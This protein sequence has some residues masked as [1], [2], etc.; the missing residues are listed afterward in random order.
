M[1]EA[2]LI[3]IKF[4]TPFITIYQ[5]IGRDKNLTVRNNPIEE[6]W[7]KDYEIITTTGKFFH[8]LQD[9][10]DPEFQ[11]QLEYLLTDDL[12]PLVYDDPVI[13][14]S[15]AR[16]IARQGLIAVNGL[17]IET[18]RDLKD[19]YDQ[20]NK[21]LEAKREIILKDSLQESENAY[22]LYIPPGY[23]VLDKLLR[24]LIMKNVDIFEKNA[25][26][27]VTCFSVGFFLFIWLVLFPIWKVLRS[28]RFRL[29]AMFKI[30]PINVIRS[31]SFIKNYVIFNTNGI[32]VPIR[33]LI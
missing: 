31:N 10:D 25:T 12:C 32:L 4:G 30:I 33:K 1:V 28:E 27:L 11:I 3:F 2:S 7:Y 9:I 15:G 29:Q 26:V 19:T 14:C 6:E 20:S 24:D 21:T 17:L 5:Y 23:Q 13:G 8:S 16:E 22:W 18:M